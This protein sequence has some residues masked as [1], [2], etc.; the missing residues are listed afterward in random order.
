[1]TRS[2]VVGATLVATFISTPAIA[3]TGRFTPADTDVVAPRLAHSAREAAGLGQPDQEREEARREREQDRQ[4]RQREREEE[5]AERVVELY[6]D[7]LEALDEGRWD[8]AADRF[9]RV[10]ETKGPRTDAALYWKAYAQNRQGQRPE[11]LQTIAELLKAYPNSR[12]LQQAKALEVEVRRD[13]GQP[14]RPESQSDEE[15]KL[16]ALQ[17]LQHS[18]PERAI[19]MLE[20]ILKGTASPKLK[21]RAL[22]VL[23]QSDSPRAR[24]V[25]ANVAK[26][27]DLPD[28]QIR[29]IQ[30]LGVH[31]GTENRALLSEI[32]DASNDIDIKRRV[33]RAFMVAGEKDRVMA[34]ATGEKIPE[35]RAEAV[36]QL[37]VMGAH[38]EL[39]QLYQKEASIDVKR[40]IL[41][42]MFVGG[43][44]TRLI[45]LARS[46]PNAELRR[47]A[48][49]NLGL[50]GNKQAGEALVEIYGKDSDR[51]I[52]RAVIQA[53]FIQGNGEAL[54]ALARKETDKSMQVE[55]VQKMSLMGGNK[56]VQAYLEELLK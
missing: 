2:C 23:A 7:G 45:E 35:L 12:Y 3:E 8:R 28:L 46:E 34:A 15:L 14:V 42:A 30:Y 16:M 21:G 56:A 20:G 36:Q 13:A 4:E 18:D 10:A 49:R 27:N 44:A 47:L 33:L 9:G 53:L 11:A 19:P 38:A 48:V 31:G 37:G 39:A 29:A 26:G 6:D 25:L 52:R 41:Q 51:D 54:V 50:I 40:R 17:G 43:D 55:M 1:M 5:R 32:Y 24:T 22:F